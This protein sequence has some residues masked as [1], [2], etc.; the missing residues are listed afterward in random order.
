MS[1]IRPAVLSSKPKKSA[2]CLSKSPSTNSRPNETLAEDLVLLDVREAEEVALVQLPHSVHIPM[3]DIPGRLHELDPEAEIVVYC[4][5]G[6]RS[7]RVAHFLHQHDFERAVSLR[8]R[9]RRLGYRD[10]TRV[11]PATK[12]VLR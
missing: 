8:R 1:S 7:L 6:V 5:H 12:S 4:H 2:R 9:N 11:W 3:G 10:R